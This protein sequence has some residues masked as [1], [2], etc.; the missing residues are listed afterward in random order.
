MLFTVV[1]HNAWTAR[2]FPLF[3]R[4]LQPLAVGPRTAELIRILGGVLLATED[5]AWDAAEG[6]MY[7]TGDRTRPANPHGSFLDVP[8]LKLPLFVPEFS[9]DLLAA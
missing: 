8:V 3:V 7:P 4:G 1:R 9:G 2:E 5:E 6:F